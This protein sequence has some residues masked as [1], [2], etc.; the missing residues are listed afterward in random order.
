MFLSIF[1]PEYG[2]YGLFLMS[3]ITFPTLLI[4][5]YFIKKEHER[6]KGYDIEIDA[7]NHNMTVD[8]FIEKE[9]KEEIKPLSNLKQ[10]VNNIHEKLHVIFMVLF[11]CMPVII[12]IYS[13]SIL[14]FADSYFIHFL[15]YAA[16]WF[17][18]GYFLMPFIEG[19]GEGAMVFIPHYIAFIIVFIFSSLIVTVRWLI[20]VLW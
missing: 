13:S 11:F 14:I 9:L 18:Y 19:F 1:K 6:T 20:G 2:Y 5:A 12:A 10:L 16:I 17:G 4:W 8:E 15:V 7:K 3:I